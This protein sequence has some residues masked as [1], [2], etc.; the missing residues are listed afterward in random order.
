MMPWDVTTRWN[1]SY[2]MLNF[3]LD[4]RAA[5][6]AIIDEKEMKMRQYELSDGD[7]GIVK[8]LRDVL[9]VNQSPLCFC[10][11]MYLSYSD[12]ADL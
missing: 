2:D 9:K 4:Y 7:W 1:S 12:S 3:A 6:D 11:D 10:R 5:I 8:Q